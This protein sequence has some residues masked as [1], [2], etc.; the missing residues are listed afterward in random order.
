MKT[1][2][3]IVLIIGF[4][5]CKQTKE[6]ISRKIENVAINHCIDWSTDCSKYYIQLAFEK[7]LKGDKQKLIDV[8]EKMNDTTLTDEQ[9]LDRFLVLHDGLG[10]LPLGSY[11]IC[12]SCC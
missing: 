11:G 1:S 2:F 12:E 7:R 6:V 9:F 5:S 8:V 4:V 3:I 10:L